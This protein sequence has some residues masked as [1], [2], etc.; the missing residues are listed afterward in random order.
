VAKFVL[1]SYSLLLWLEVMMGLRNLG[2]ICGLVRTNLLPRKP[3]HRGPPCSQLCRAMDLAC[4]LYPKRVLCLQRS[5]ATTVLLRRHGIAAEM[6][7]GARVLPFRSHS[8]VEVDRVV[9]NDKPYMGEI[10][11]PIERL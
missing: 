9:V 8:W 11:S 10:Y 3:S 4:V 1:E 7:I 2:A 5:A 6:V